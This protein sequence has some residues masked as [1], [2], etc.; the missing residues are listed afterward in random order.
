MSPF[1]IVGLETAL[2]LSL[3]L[4]E[5]GIITLNQ[6]ITKLTSIPSDIAK[7]NKG[8]LKKGSVADIV[9]FDPGEEVTIDRNNF[10]SKGKNSPFDG[11]NLKGRVKYTISNGKIA[12]KT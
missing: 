7:L 5:K 2:P 11:W 8:T 3:A 12:Y 6:L 1:G 9:I 10:L 4:V